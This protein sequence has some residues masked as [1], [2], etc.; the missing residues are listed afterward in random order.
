MAGREKLITVGTAYV[1]LDLLDFPLED[2]G[3][4][5]E[6]ELAGRQYTVGLGGSALNFARICSGLDLEAVFVG[7]IGS[8]LLGRMVLP[9]LMEESGVTPEL[10]I[11]DNEKVCSNLGI[12]FH[13][14]KN[15]RS[16]IAVAG[17]ANKFLTSD[18]VKER[19]VPH[20]DDSKYLYIGGIYKLSKL[21]PAFEDLI[22]PAKERGLKL[23]LDHGRIPSEPSAAD[24]EIYERLRKLTQQVDYYFPS[25]DE[26]LTLWDVDSIEAGL[27]KLAEES[28]ATVVVKNGKEGVEYLQNDQLQKARAFSVEPLSTTGAGDSF[29]AGFIAAQNKG[30]DVA[31]SAR[32]GCATAGLKISRPVLP[33]YAEV[34]AFMQ[35]EA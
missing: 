1:D 34:E 35:N 33:T 5:L 2:T 13:D 23:I 22:A 6:K 11:E 15:D 20:L 31:R 7:K 3:L 25:R 16:S 14:G 17:D 29:N 21:L 19:I 18:E 8:D 27:R 4:P 12:N 24:K 10:I 9:K 30:A 28:N 26:F 32:F